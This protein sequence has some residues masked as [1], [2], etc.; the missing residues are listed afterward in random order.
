MFVIIIVV[1][2]PIAGMIYSAL[3]AP[4][5][6]SMLIEEKQQKLIQIGQRMDESIDDETA[7]AIKKTVMTRSPSDIDSLQLQLHDRMLKLSYQYRGVDIGYSVPTIEQTFSLLPPRW[8]Y[9]RKLENGIAEAINSKGP[10][11]QY[12]MDHM[13]GLL[14]H[15]RPVVRQNDIIAL[16]WARE[17]IPPQYAQ[18]RNV[19]RTIFVITMLGLLGGIIGTIIIIRNMVNS[20]NI[21][22]NGLVG[23]QKDFTYRL[24][25]V[26]GEMGEI[27]QAINSM[28]EALEEKA[29]LE[30]QLQRSERLA[31]LGQ[32][33]AGIAHEMRNPMAIVKA[34][35]QLMQ[36]QYKDSS[37][38]QQYLDVIK[39]QVDR[40]DK[41]VKELLD[42]SR[43]SKSLWEDISLVE[44][45][46]SVITFTRP[47]MDQY[48]IELSEKYQI[49]LP[50]II[51]DGER[52]KQ[53]FVNI[54]INAVQSMPK[55][56]QLMISVYSD[57]QNVYASFA[58]TGSGIADEDIEN[59]FNPFYTTKYSG[60]G[61]GLAISHN[62]I[63][64]HGGT[65]A[66]TRSKDGGS[67]FTVS[68]PIRRDDDAASNIDNR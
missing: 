14:L 49:D 37:E 31:A 16:A 45:L 51:A 60:T 7:A 8:P 1:A 30:E 17:M 9:D 56:G 12:F 33:V 13:G 44:L 19:R 23:I 34:T 42:F 65:I 52:L 6:D 25:S 67:I 21:I 58:D 39:E 50:L 38:M 5:I 36:K 18:S 10:Y 29:K 15:V 47:Y 20:A 11:S 46:K 68:I 64:M 22:K 3:F 57:E 35:V 53:V 27:A 63:A 43:P 48:H 62:I 28:A 32:L 24:P 54:I 61:L 66:V 41:I 26:S 40:Q 59:I 2:A 55:G 4:G